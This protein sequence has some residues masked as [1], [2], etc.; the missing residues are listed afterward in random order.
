MTDLTCK[1]PGCGYSGGGTKRGMCAKHYQR[2]CALGEPDDLSSLDSAMRPCRLCGGSIQPERRRSLYCSDSCR[3]AATWGFDAPLRCDAC[4]KALRATHTSKRSGPRKC[5]PC[6]YHG[7][8]GYKRGCRCEVCVEAERDRFRR[9][10]DRL[11]AE[12]GVSYRTFWEKRE[13]ERT[14]VRPRRAGGKHWIDRA[15]RLAIYERDNWTCH[16]CG[17]GIDPDAH[18]NDDRGASL[19]HL[20]PRSLGGTDEPDNLRTCHRACNSRRGVKDL[21]E[22]LTIGR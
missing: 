5:R 8:G 18:W 16:L 2:W 22:V 15:V 20:I 13:R 3:S 11:R 6:S 4:G 19:D 21:E 1:V 9:F 7:Q 10:N 17:E 12:H 14:G